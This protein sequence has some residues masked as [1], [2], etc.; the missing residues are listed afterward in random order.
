MVL[1]NAFSSQCWGFIFLMCYT[2]LNLLLLLHKQGFV[3]S[4]MVTTVVVICMCQFIT[5]FCLPIQQSG[6][7]KEVEKNF[8]EI[9]MKRQAHWFCLYSPTDGQ[10]SLLFA[11]IFK[12]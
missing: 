10:F 3:D 6:S 12:G 5:Y 4:Q 8:F 9:L 11:L 2:H 7:I 1:L